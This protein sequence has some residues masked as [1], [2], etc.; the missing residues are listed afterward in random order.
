[1]PE[2]IEHALA[3]PYLAQ[4]NSVKGTSSLLTLVAWLDVKLDIRN[5]LLGTKYI[6]IVLRLVYVLL[7]EYWL[8]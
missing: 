6:I 5:V 2:S 3:H 1:M 7:L 8:P 4:N